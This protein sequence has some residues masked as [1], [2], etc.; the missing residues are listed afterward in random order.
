MSHV[1]SVVRGSDTPR[2]AASRYNVSNSKIL[3]IPIKLESIQE[4]RDT[5]LVESDNQQQIY[6]GFRT[7]LNL[8]SV[9]GQIYTE[10]ELR[11]AC[12]RRI[13][14]KS[15]YSE[16]L[17]KFWAPKSTLTYFLNVLFAPLKCSSLKH[18]WDLMGVGKITKRI[19]R[20]VIEKELL[21]QKGETKLTFSRTKKHTLWQHQK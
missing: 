20:K 7:N 6:G 8:P 2:N 11:L 9:Q 14:E 16:I 1:I 3:G 18:L 5:T 12:K 4:E 17:V 21:I 15:S 10:W 13:L 19:V